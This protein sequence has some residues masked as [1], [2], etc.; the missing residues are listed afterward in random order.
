MLSKEYPTDP[1]MN[2]SKLKI[3][4][5]G[6]EEFKYAMDNPK[7]PSESQNLGSAVHVLILEPHRADIIATVPKFDGN[8]REG[9][10]FKMMMQG[11]G[12][13]YFPVTSKKV[14]KQEKGKFYEVDQEEK[15]FIFEMGSKY[16]KVLTKPQDYL[17]LTEE[18]HEQAK[19]MAEAAFKNEDTKFILEAS[20]HYEKI[21]HFTYRGIDFKCQLDTQGHMFFADLKTTVIRNDDWAI[22]NEIKKRRYHFQMAVYSKVFGKDWSLIKKYI[23]FVR[24]EP[25][26]A[27]FPVQL[28]DELFDEGCEQFDDAC[29][30]YIE[31][32]KNNP[33]FIANNRLRVI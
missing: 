26:Y 29:D 18:E 17:I 23:L 20:H 11:W 31:C 30:I 7:K 4:L 2:Q 12:P 9:K 3:I 6:V 14:K 8:S 32:L 15:D 25:P 16:A 19:R 10:I 33:N 24:S 5:D 21:H 1:R 13:D 27:V 28:S 22:R